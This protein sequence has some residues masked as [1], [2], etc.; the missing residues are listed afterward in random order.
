MKATKFVLSLALALASFGAEAKEGACGVPSNYG[1]EAEDITRMARLQTTRFMG[2]A[3]AL[4]LDN[5]AERQ[6]ISALF[7]GGFSPITSAERVIGKY[8]CRT[9][10]LG[11]NLPAIVYGWFDCDVFP[12]EAAL[13]IR[14]TSGSQRF[15]GLLAPAAN[16]LA[17]KG[18][19][20]YG[21][22]DISKFYGQ[23]SERNQVGCFSAIDESMNHFVLELPAPKFESVHDVIEF[24]R[25]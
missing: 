9:I 11:G 2:L 7:S 3:A 16:G 25:R 17:Y 10:K 22:E 23:D 21:Y 18:A 13:V 8:Q 4:K 24:K 6:T 15:F 20:H 12:E 19:L 1:L 14:K 5:S